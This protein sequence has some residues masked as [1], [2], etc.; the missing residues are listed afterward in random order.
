MPATMLPRFLCVAAILCSGTAAIANPTLLPQPQRVQYGTGSLP[1]AG[2]TIAFSPAPATEDRF[3]AN[4]L[5]RG[6]KEK[7]GI[8]VGVTGSPRGSAI[9]LERTGTVDPLPLPGE[10]AGPDSREA[11]RLSVDAKGV[12][13]AGRS[14]AA[15][16]YGVQTLLQL[17][18]ISGAS[19]SIPYVRIE[20]WPSL[21]YRATL[22]D[23]GSEGPMSTVD[24]VKSEIDLLARFKANQYFLYSEAN[25]ELDGYPLLNPGARFTKAQVREII[26]YARERHI[27]VVPAVELYGHLHDLFRIER[28]A[29]L[30]D[31]PHGG[32]L[33]P[34]NPKVK[35]LLQD[36]VG[37]LADLFPGPFVDIGFD[38]TFA[39]EQAAER[40]GAGVTPVKLFVDQLSEVAKLFQAKGKHVMAYGDIMVKFPAIVS[41]LP[42][43][44]IALA[45]YYDPQPDPEYKKWLDPLVSQHVPHMVLPGVSSWSEVAPDFDM[46]FANVDTWLAAGRKS[47]ALGIVNTVWTDDGQVLLQMSDP[48][49]AY[50]AAASWQ[51]V[52]IAHSE[53]FAEYARLMY[54][55]AAAA[56]VAQAFTEL[57]SAEQKL[58][59]V[60]GQQTMSGVWA[61]PFSPRVLDSIRKHREELR[62]CRLH[63]E[64]AQESLYRARSKG[65][66]PQDLPSLLVGAR[67]F[68]YAGMKYLYAIEMA[69]S[70]QALPPQPTHQQ[71]GAVLSQGITPQTHSR[72]SDLMDAISG[73]KE[74]YRRA[75]LT[76]YTD[77]RLPAALGRWDAEYEYWRRAQSRLR[78]LIGSFHDHDRLPSLTELLSESRVR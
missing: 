50:G 78:E 38:E 65:V 3:A 27:D 56:D 22:V 15:I 52:P 64:N 10:K 58:Q 51:S 69:D 8:A 26:R 18:D 16:Y 32:E 61:D 49:I 40:A 33:N 71:L 54:P 17:V 2:L 57:N 13:L 44:V 35:A 37:Q 72:T 34:Q 42:P 25:I 29:D 53:F 43:G 36:W 23:V 68:D 28:Y 20:D 48:G 62:Q 60:F 31:F 1:V 6:L 12:R 46:T 73:L 14:S 9:V 5:A 74:P 11:Y 76:E 77:Y 59:T 4:E 45:W 19:P 47:G 24:R 55:A 67:L 21:P 39:I 30:A 7:T 70:W 41:Q 75:W 63:A 66:W